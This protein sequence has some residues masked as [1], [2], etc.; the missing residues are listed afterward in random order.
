MARVSS[1]RSIELRTPDVDAA[2]AFYE[3]LWGLEAVAREGDAVYLRGTGPEHHVA[4]L[5]DADSP[6]VARVNLGA[7][8]RAAVDAIFARVEAAGGAIVSTPAAVDEPG[9]GYGFSFVDP[10]GRMFAIVAEVTQHDRLGTRPDVPV[11]ISHVV[12]SSA[13]ADATAGFYRDRLGFRVRDRTKTI[14]FLGCNADHHSVAFAHGKQ[15]ALHHIAFELPNIDAVMRGT[16]R[17][18]RRGIALEW[19]VGRHG[20]GNNIFAYFFDP[21]GFVI[22]YTT[23]MQQVDDAAYR[24][25][26]PQDWDRPANADQWGVAGPPSARFIERAPPSGSRTATGT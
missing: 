7:P 19:G 20:P 14:A 5:R 9:G 11:K 21:I 8:D 4:V 15:P 10:E 13:D 2:R 12:M 6:G 3:D 16:G 1:V 24:V 23:E 18:K 25:G 26:T 22:E 17:L